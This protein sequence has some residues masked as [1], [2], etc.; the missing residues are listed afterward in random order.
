MVPLPYVLK[1]RVIIDG[2]EL[3]GADKSCSIRVKSVDGAE[4]QPVDKPGQTYGG[5]V[6]S[7]FQYNIPTYDATTQPAG[8]KAGQKACIEIYH[9]ATR[10]NVT[11]PGRGSCPA[12]GGEIT[13]LSPGDALGFAIN[14][15]PNDGLHSLPAVAATTP[16]DPVRATAGPRSAPP[17][18]EK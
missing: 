3:T 1:A 14:G 9:G 6:P 15:R 8:A 16:A 5:V 12:G 11:Y 7:R 10:L 17:V 18:P 4:F 13:V 2:S